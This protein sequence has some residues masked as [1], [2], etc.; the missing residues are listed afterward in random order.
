MTFQSTV[1]QDLATGI[2]GDFAVVDGGERVFPYALDSADA[3]N[4]VIARAFTIKS[5]G[6]AQ[7]GGSGVFAGLLVNP[8]SYAYQGLFNNASAQLT[9]PNGAQ[10]E[11]AKRGYVF[12]TL[13]AAAAIGAYLVYNT[14]TGVL[15]TVTDPAVPGS[16]NALVPNARVAIYTISAAGIAVVEL[17]N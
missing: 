6:V 8:K 9:L 1:R 14:T 11:F 17:S 12:V 16:G 4:N 2:V 15:S 5:E 7:A 10:G 13:P 3:A